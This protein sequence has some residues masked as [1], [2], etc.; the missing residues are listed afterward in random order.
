MS[1]S[2][3]ATVPAPPRLSGF[4][5]YLVGFAALILIWSAASALF[6]NPT[7]L[8]TPLTVGK[9]VF[10][11]TVD[12]VLLD[13]ATASL[14]RVLAGFSIGA[15]A[16]ILLGILI[17]LSATVEKATE[18]SVELF[19]S[20]PPYAMIPL[21]LLAFG[22][23]PAGKWGILAYATFFP[24]LVSTVAGISST[25]KRLVE[26][27]RTLGASRVFIVIH[28]LLPAAIPQMVVGLRLGFG[29][30]WLSLIAAEMV[31]SS[32]GLGFLISDARELLETE[33]VLAGMLLIGLLG[34]A[35][36]QLFI[37]LERRVRPV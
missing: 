34:Y 32:D 18:P 3:A 33:I 2:A 37:L 23:H 17:G 5:L 15:V 11:L 13:H 35:F 10:R 7:F 19:R 31:A 36:N 16:A 6:Q 20:I 27:A 14:Q 22:I 29:T 30:A 1:A 12:G 25:P 26:A 8:P 4:A 24:V 9:T 28:V 21:A